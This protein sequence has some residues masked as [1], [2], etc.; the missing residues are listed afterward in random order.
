M[1]PNIVIVLLESTF[2]ENKAFDYLPARNSSFASKENTTLLQGPLYVNAVGGGTW[3]S[4]F[5]A[6]TGMPASLFG[7]SGGY[8]HITLSPYIKHTFV[9][10]LVDKGYETIG[11]YPIP[12]DFY[13][14]RQAYLKYGFKKFIDGNDL[15]IQNPWKS[16]DLD[17]SLIHI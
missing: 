3:V 2:D 7:W 6:I 16:T 5:E 15:G 8:T 13:S 12:G 11:L 10:Y 4:E 14:A 17:L 9:H 1:Q